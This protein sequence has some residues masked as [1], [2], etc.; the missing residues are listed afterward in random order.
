MTMRRKNIAILTGGGDCPGINAV[1]R[2]VAKKAMLEKEMEVIGIEDGYHGIVDNRWRPLDYEA[3]SGILTLGGTILGTSKT[4]NPYRYAVQKGNRLEFRNLSKITIKNLKN[5]DIDSLVCIG[6]DGTLGIAYRLYKDGI[7]IVGVP[8]TIDNDLRGTDITFGFDSAV[9]IATEGLDRIHTIAES[10]HRIMIVEVMGHTAGWIALYS[11]VAGGGD[12]ILI[13]EIPYD[14]HRI[15]EK[16]KER[17]KKGKR[18]SIVVIAEGAKPKGGDIVIQ[19]FVK[20]SSDP[21]RLGG[22]GF[23]LG[24]QI[25][26]ATRLETRTVVMG[27]LLRGGS[28][29]SFDR[30]LATNLGM[31]AVDLVEDKKFGYMVGV[32]E[33]SLVAVPLKDVAKGPK[34][35]PF[36][37][38][39]IKAAR[40]LGT[41]FGD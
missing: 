15:V 17:N 39:M 37:H 20:E 28:P 14:L 27:H 29:T 34:L 1:I 11:G 23:L 30:I 6:G 10:L 31:K 13:P 5:L 24:R 32:K 12:I 19:R 22:I 8:K 4:V 25:E 3:V 40:S 35:I 21:I 16:V 2:A 33:N 38:P 18:F 9:S 36:N 7:P 26:E 41:C